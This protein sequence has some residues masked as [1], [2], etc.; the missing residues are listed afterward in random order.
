MK[1]ENAMMNVVLLDRTFQVFKNKHARLPR[2]VLSRATVLAETLCLTI[3]ETLLVAYT[4]CLNLQ[5][6]P[7][8]KQKARSILG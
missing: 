4:S 5:Q 8:V 6:F 7:R 2:E 1:I 3:V